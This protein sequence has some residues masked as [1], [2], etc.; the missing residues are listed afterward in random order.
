MNEILEIKQGVYDNRSKYDCHR[1]GGGGTHKIYSN[2][3]L[4]QSKFLTL[5]QLLH[6][7]ISKELTHNHMIAL[8][9]NR[10]TFKTPSCC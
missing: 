10:A 1:Q 2:Y 7:N 9:F 5:I 8:N 3:N 4:I 6:T